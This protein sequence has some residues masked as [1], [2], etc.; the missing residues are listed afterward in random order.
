M[1]CASFGAFKKAIICL[2]RS[3]KAIVAFVQRPGTEVGIQEVQS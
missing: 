2:K 3:S 1:S